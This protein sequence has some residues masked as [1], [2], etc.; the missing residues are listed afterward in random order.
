MARKII[1]QNRRARYDY[2]IEETFE[3]GIVLEG[4]EVKSLRQGRASINEAYASDEGG[5]IYLINAHIDEYN[6]AKHFNHSERR[7]RK[8]LMNRREMN[9]LLGAVQ[10]K[11]ITLI[12]M[13][14]YFNERGRVKVE[15]GIA[16]GKRQVDKRAAIKEREWNRDKSRVMK[17][18]RRG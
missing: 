8:L 18:H 4:T 2:A 7:P 11:G 1:A 3:V 13:N 6:S 14:I 10:R 16:V 12:P 17:D 9:K 15:L 5:E